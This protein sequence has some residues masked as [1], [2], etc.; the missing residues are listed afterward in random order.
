MCEARYWTGVDESTVRCELCPHGCRIGDGSSG[1]CRVREG[2]DG[3]LLAMG[4]GRLSSV[5]VDPIEKKPLYHFHP[6]SE[7]LSIGGWGCNF[8]CEFCQN[9]TISQ[10]VREG[11]RYSPPEVVRLA[12]SDGSVGIAYTYNEPVV[13]YEFVLDCAR[14]AHEAGVANVMVT[15]GYLN[16]EPASEL[17][18]V[19]DGLNIDIKSIREEF[20][21]EHCGGSLAPVLDFATQ[22]VSAGCHVEITNL[23][24]P[25]LNDSDEEVARLGKWIAA[26]VGRQVPLHISAYHPRYKLSVGPTPEESLRRA[27]GICRSELAYVYLGN[28]FMDVGHSTVCPGCD[29]ELIGRRGYVVDVKGICDGLCTGC[30]RPVDAVM[31]S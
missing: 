21:R 8:R 18:A 22:A 11:R 2:R 27:H 4:Y 12:V 25:G 30:G 29:A 19:I 16:A 17:L 24:I 1:L 31:G 13:G 5:N 3:K 15:N 20:Y 28:V 6:G 9:W 23:L 14:V 7:I 10:Q 26:N